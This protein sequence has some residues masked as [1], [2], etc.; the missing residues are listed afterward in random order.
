MLKPGDAASNFIRGQAVAL[1]LTP[2]HGVT[3][4]LSGPTPLTDEEF[5]SVI[6]RAWLIALAMIVAMTATLWIALRSASIV[7]AV[8]LATFAGLVVTTALGLAVVGRLNLISVA[9]IPLFVGLGVDF[10]IQIGVRFQAELDRTSGPTRALRKAAADLGPALLLAA[11]AICTGFLWRFCNL[12]C[13]HH[14]TR[15]HL[16]DGHGRRLAVQRDA[17][18]GACHPDPA[19]AAP[20]QTRGTRAHP[21]RSRDPGVHRRLVLGAFGLF[22]LASFALLPF[23]RFDFNPLHLPSPKGEAMTTLKDLVHDL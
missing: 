16:D 19:Q 3:V 8:M 22:A 23:V 10:G 13:R 17:D 1:G 20:P 21:S 2:A 4:R 12:L 11:G 7:A 6:D 9:F 5:G 18:P 14:R 15:H